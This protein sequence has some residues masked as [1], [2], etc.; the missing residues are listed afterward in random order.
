MILYFFALTCR[1][2]HD[3]PRDLLAQNIMMDGRPILPQGWHF[4][5]R[6]CGPNGV[7]PITPL[8]RID[9]PVQYFIIDYDASIMFAPGQSHLLE[10]FEGDKRKPPEVRKNQQYDAF[11]V[12]VFTLGDVFDKDFFQACSC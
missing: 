7:D 4:T 9:H 10:G 2:I 11:K 8:T 5:R 1:K 12:D 3:V 6:G